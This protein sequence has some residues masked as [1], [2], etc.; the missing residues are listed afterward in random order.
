MRRR[1]M[2][3]PLGTLRAMKPKRS[4]GWDRVLLALMIPLG[5]GLLVLGALQLLRVAGTG[6]AALAILVAWVLLGCAWAR[7]RFRNGKPMF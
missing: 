1:S 5:V 6:G 7:E 3:L 4:S 2:L